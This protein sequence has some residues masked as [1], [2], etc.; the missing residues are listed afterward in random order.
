AMR[1]GARK[2]SDEAE[3]ID[4]T[5]GMGGNRRSLYEE[6]QQIDRVYAQSD[7]GKNATEAYNREIDALNLKYQKIKEV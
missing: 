3:Q 5:R 4:K 7:Q 2:F 1:D 6:R